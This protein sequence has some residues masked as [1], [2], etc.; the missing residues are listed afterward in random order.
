MQPPQRNKVPFPPAATAIP[1]DATYARAHCWV[2]GGFLTT[3]EGCTLF[4][5]ARLGRH[6]FNDCRL[7]GIPRVGELVSDSQQSGPFF[8]LRRGRHLDVTTHDVQGCRQQFASV[9]VSGTRFAIRCARMRLSLSPRSLRFVLPHFWNC[10]VGFLILN[11]ISRARLVAH[12]APSWSS[13]MSG[14]LP[15]PGRLC[16][17]ARLQAI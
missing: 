4:R 10:H 6:F 13:V 15:L 5:T 17:R 1:D 9:A 14:L 8:F 11:M 12:R 2:W 16:V 7:D 3:L